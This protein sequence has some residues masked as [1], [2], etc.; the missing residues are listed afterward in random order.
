MVFAN[1]VISLILLVGIGLVAV[2][3]PESTGSGPWTGFVLV[4]FPLLLDTSILSI[5][6]SVMYIQNVREKKYSNTMHYFSIVLPI[7]SYI[8]WGTALMVWLL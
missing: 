6:A 7:P 2:N 1:S 5:A 8:L 4:I 3:L